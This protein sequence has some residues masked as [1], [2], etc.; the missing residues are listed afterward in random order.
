MKTMVVICLA[1]L[2]GYA[3]IAVLSSTTAPAVAPDPTRIPKTLFERSAGFG[4][5]ETPKPML[6][7]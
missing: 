3:V 2:L 1:V 7:K 5:Y 4:S 6:F